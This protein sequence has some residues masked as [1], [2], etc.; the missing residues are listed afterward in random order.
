MKVFTVLEYGEDNIKCR[1]VDIY[2]TLN[3]AVSRVSREKSQH[4]GTTSTFHIIEKSVK[5]LHGIS[6]KID[7]KKRYLEAN[8]QVNQ[9]PKKFKLASLIKD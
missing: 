5:G 4:A 6:F 7:G 3:G 2:G 8:I 1:V 9:Q